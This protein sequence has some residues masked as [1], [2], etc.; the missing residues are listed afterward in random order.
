MK[1]AARNPSRLEAHPTPN[2]L[3]IAEAN[4][5]NPAPKLERMKSFPANTE[6]A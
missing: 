3:Y 5:G 6:A 1:A 4:N 2:F